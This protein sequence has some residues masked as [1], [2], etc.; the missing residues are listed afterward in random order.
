[1]PLGSASGCS[2]DCTPEQEHPTL[3][4]VLSTETPIPTR[5]VHLQAALRA[6]A[7][8]GSPVI[9]A[10][11]KH[12]LVPQSGVP[13]GYSAQSTGTATLVSGQARAKVRVVCH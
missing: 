1:M 6:E 2:G 7:P 3:R 13:G 4:L 10:S 9:V 5:T 12:V 11:G 8:P